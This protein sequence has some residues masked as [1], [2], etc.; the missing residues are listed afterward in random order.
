M[1]RSG[2]VW[3]GK[4]VL[5]WCG[6]VWQGTARSGKARQLR[7]GRVGFGRARSGVARQ[8]KAVMARH[9]EVWRGMARHGKAIKAWTLVH[10]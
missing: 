2:T 1:A 10:V 9:G 5:A 8:G 3:Q 6:E 7:R 4:A